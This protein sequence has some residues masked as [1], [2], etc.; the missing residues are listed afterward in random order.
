MHG[1]LAQ[2]STLYGTVHHSYSA[3]TQLL[4]AAL[5]RKAA[6]LPNQG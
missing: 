5:Q 3:H 2:L 4:V 1:S 6:Y